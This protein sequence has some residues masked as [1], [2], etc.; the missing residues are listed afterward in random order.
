MGERQGIITYGNISVVYIL[1]KY[2]QL[3][4]LNVFGP[5]EPELVYRQ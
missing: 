3:H 2:K 1:N 5:Q 4:N